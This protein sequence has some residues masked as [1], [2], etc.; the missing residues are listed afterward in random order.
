MRRFPRLRAGTFIEAKK[1]EEAKAAG[2]EFPRLRA[3]T[4]I[5][6]WRKTAIH[7]LANFISPPSGGDFH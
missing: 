1:L 6:A 5:E 4:F 7:E 3:G 2:E